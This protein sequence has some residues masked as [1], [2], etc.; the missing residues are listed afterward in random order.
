GTSL[1]STEST[2]SNSS[3]QIITP[4]S[5]YIMSSPMPTSYESTT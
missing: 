1:Q 5:S 4:T 3:H 2:V